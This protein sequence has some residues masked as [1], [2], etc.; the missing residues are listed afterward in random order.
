MKETCVILDDEKVREREIDVSLTIMPKNIS[1]GRFYFI[2][3]TI[4]HI[5]IVFLLVDDFNVS[6]QQVV[7]PIG[8]TLAC[9]A[10][11]AIDDMIVESEELLTL[12]FTTENSNDFV[13]KNTTVVVISD[14][15]GN[16][17][18]FNAII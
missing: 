13:N 14:N 7:I 3:M 15:D 4:I 6:N 18:T 8:W 11:A 12:V 10:V 9:L 1:S 17:K 2:T 5:F 16:T